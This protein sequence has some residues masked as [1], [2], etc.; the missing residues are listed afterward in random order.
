MTSP[1][2]PRTSDRPCPEPLLVATVPEGTETTYASVK[3]Q[4]VQPDP[5]EREHIQSLYHLFTE[6]KK[7][8]I[9]ETGNDSWNLRYASRITK[10]NLPFLHSSKTLEV[11]IDPLLPYR[12]PIRDLVHS[13]SLEFQISSSQSYFF[14]SKADATHIFEEERKQHRAEA[15]AREKSST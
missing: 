4:F 7:A 9:A 14:K 2:I 3:F 6:M 13:G 12:D 5:R 8:I 1:E 15:A 11:V 10:E